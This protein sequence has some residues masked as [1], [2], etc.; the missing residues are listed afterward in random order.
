MR[1]KEHR[2]KIRSV[3][4]FLSLYSLFFILSSSPS[5]AASKKG[6]STATFLRLE[7]G[8]R[9]IGMGSAQTAITDDA[10][11]LWWNPAGMV[12]SGREAGI[13][14]TQ[15]FEEISSQFASFVLPLRDG[16]SA[17]GT[18]ITYFT[19]PGLEGYTAA[20]VNTGK[21]DANSYAASLAYSMRLDPKMSVGVNVKTIGQ[22]LDTD[23]GT[24]F[25]A[26]FGFQITENKL[27]FGA[28]AQNLGPTM[29]VASGISNPLPFNLRAGAGYKVHDR[30]LTAL[31]FE[32]PSDGDFKPHLGSE[33]LVSTNL[34]LRAGYQPL[35]NL[36]SS[37]AG[38]TLGFSFLRMIGGEAEVLREGYQNLYEEVQNGGAVLMTLDYAFILYGEL[39]SAHRFSLNFRF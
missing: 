32:M 23:S 21:I 25:A 33:F 18:S 8:A 26:D 24:G 1:Q 15:L 16:K 27:F 28:V 11:S 29:K 4:F 34:T 7:Q 17:L 5:Y 31:D 39:D 6:T 38:L 22:K 30:I 3:F 13:S 37:M 36:D 19:I 35:K 14:H 20:G 10:H 12:R 9:G 2:A